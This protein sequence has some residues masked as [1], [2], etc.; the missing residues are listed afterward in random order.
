MI[1]FLTFKRGVQGAG[2]HNKRR[3]LCGGFVVFLACVLHC[4]AARSTCL[5]GWRN[6][7]AASNVARTCGATSNIAC[8]TWMPHTYGNFPASHG[9]DGNRD[10]FVHTEPDFAATV[11]HIFRLDFQRTQHVNYVVFYNRKDCCAE[12]A[13]GAQIRIGAS[14]DWTQNTWCATLTSDAI[15]TYTC[16]LTG[17]Y[18][19]VVT[20]VDQ[21]QLR[22][23]LNFAELEV[24]SNCEVCP[25][26]QFDFDF[27]QMLTTEVPYIVSDAAN[28]NP[29]TGKFDSLCGNKACAGSTGVRVTGTVSTGISAGNGAS[30]PVHFVQGTTATTMQWGAGSIPEEF[31]ICSVTRY[32]GATRGRILNALN[33]IEG[34]CDWLHGHWREGNIAYAGSAYYGGSGPFLRYRIPTET[35]WVVSC[36]RNKADTSTDGVIVN[37]ITARNSN[38]GQGECALGINHAEPSDWQLSKLYIWDKHLSDINFRLAASALFIALSTGTPASTCAAPTWCNAGTYARFANHDVCNPAAVVPSVSMQSCSKDSDCSYAGCQRVGSNYGC[39][40]NGFWGCCSDN[41]LKCWRGSSWT[42]AG[43]CPSPLPCINSC[44]QCPSNSGSTAGSTLM[45]DCKC[46]AGSTGGDG[47]HCSRCEAG[48]YKNT[49]GSAACIDCPVGKFSNAEVTVC[50]PLNSGSAAGSGTTEHCTCNAGSTGG[51]G[52]GNGCGLCAA[53]KYKDTIGTAPC[54]DCPIGTYSSVQGVTACQLCPASSQRLITDRTQCVF[55]AENKTLNSLKTQCVCDAGFEAG[56]AANN[57]QHKCHL[58]KP[59]TASAL[60]GFACG[61]CANQFYAAFSGQVKCDACPEGIECPR[62]GPTSYSA[63]AGADM[64]Q[65]NNIRKLQAI[66]SFAHHK[67]YYVTH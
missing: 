49:I 10:T 23:S 5:K 51:S 38:G 52:Q 4:V 28:W 44:Y 24:Y 29:T 20:P 62:T 17:R 46:N 42:D 65:G 60:P 55:C 13:S 59:G 31:T 2:R 34:T 36:G 27:Q 35:D 19:F 7:N 33:N 61:P 43:H 16:Q 57:D 45:T 67:L 22:R 9:N 54:T 50:C 41:N 30:A 53:G 48:K 3:T 26:G 39:W 56:T 15:Q 58:C 25:S 8:P 12:R 37:G 63:L 40:P 1:L 6:L 14:E 18:I 64:C 21:A 66:E 47:R 11:A 32:S